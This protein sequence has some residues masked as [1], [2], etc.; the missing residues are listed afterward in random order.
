MRTAGLARIILAIPLLFAA[1][2]HGA[3]ALPLADRLEAA[4]TPEQRAQILDDAGAA[5]D[6]GL[7]KLLRSR[8]DAALARYDY[9]RSLQSNLAALAVAERLHDA[10]QIAVTYGSL[11]SADYDQGRIGEALDLFRKGVRVAEA[12]G[13]KVRI[14]TLLRRVAACETG[15]GNHDAARIADERGLRI[16]RESGDPDTIALLLAGLGAGSVEAGEYRQAAELC[17]ESLRLAEAAHN[18]RLVRTNL[19]ALAVIYL[20]QG[21]PSLA[22]AYFE[23]MQAAGAETNKHSQARNQTILASIYERL[24]RYPEAMQAVEVSLRMARE[25]GD[26]REEMMA[27]RRLGRL[28]ESMGNLAAA[29][30]ASAKAAD[31]AERMHM[32]DVRA[33]ILSGLA[34]SCLALGERDRA[35]AVA[36]QAVSLAEPLHSRYTL[37]AALNTAGHVY[38]ALGRGADAEQSFRRAISIAEEFRTRLAGGEQEGR[39]FVSNMLINPYQELLAMKAEQGD[40]ET[41]LQLAERAKARQLLDVLAQGR[42]QSTAALTPAE[43]QHELDLARQAAAANAALAASRNDARAVAAFQKSAGELEAFRAR[44]YTAHPGLQVRRGETEPISIDQLRALLPDAQTLL[45]EFVAS[46]DWVGAFAVER[47]AG[48]RPVV[49]VARLGLAFADLRRRID[50]F[51]RA[52]ATRELSYRTSA[53]LLYRELLGP[54][55]A[56][57]RNKRVVG[58]VPDGPLWN[59][60]FQALLAADGRHWIEHCASFYAPSLTALRESARLHRAESGSGSL[61]AIG[62]ARDEAERIGRLY[63]GSSKILTGADAFESRWKLEAARFRI[64]HIATHGVL[65]G[66]NPMFSYLELRGD[67]AD[68]G[69]LEAREVLELDLHAELAVL[70]ACETAR[71]EIRS[72]EGSVGLGW[73]VMMA[74]TPSV[75]VSQWKIDAAATTELMLAFHRRIE[76]ALGRGPLRGKSEALRQAALEMLATSTY[77]HPFYWAGFQM[78]GNG[79]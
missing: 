57:L 73:A 78:L 11:G 76:R 18:D 3:D 56:Q 10:R 48:G 4:R 71:G 69:M 31:L 16:A 12:A 23:R 5:A 54:F 6:A 35:L 42:V 55:A 26:A 77:Q 66:S 25:A 8:A 49:S 72:G 1:V 7:L 15:L 41:A 2:L 79:Y 39:S 70:S 60:P 40:L 50:E 47:G 65:N 34:W 68:D 61:L 43:K 74:G 58:I 28:W 46:D 51:R 64:L 22:L 9:G 37:A 67:A 13:D 62:L 44:I 17:E 32:T 27:E 75:V 52:L 21:D 38:R 20:N 19:T 45:L 33:S 59:L 36:E 29:R 30:D 24:H 63:G 53:S 14:A